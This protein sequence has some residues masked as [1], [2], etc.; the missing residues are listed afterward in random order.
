MAKIVLAALAVLIGGSASVAVTLAQ[1]TRT[2]Q[3]SGPLTIAH[4][5]SLPPGEPACGGFYTIGHMTNT[6]Y[7][8]DYAVGLGANA[9]EIDLQFRRGGDF[10]E[11]KHGW[12]CPCA[13]YHGGICEKADCNDASSV[14]EMLTHIANKQNAIGLV[15]IDSKAGDIRPNALGYAGNKLAGEIIRELYARGY[16]GNVILGVPKRRYMNLL[17]SAHQNLRDH[18]PRLLNRVR[19]SIDQEDNNAD[20]VINQLSSFTPQIAY[21]TGVSFASPKYRDGIRRAQARGIPFTYIWTVNDADDIQSYLDVGVTAV[22]T[23]HPFRVTDLAKKRGLRLASRGDTFVCR[24]RQSTTPTPQPVQASVELTF[25]NS[26]QDT[27]WPVTTGTT[28]DPFGAVA[29]W[30]RK[31]LSALCTTDGVSTRS[32]A[33]RIRPDGYITDAHP[34]SSLKARYWSDVARPRFDEPAARIVIFK[35]GSIRVTP[36][37]LLFFA[38]NLAAQLDE[39]ADVLRKYGTESGTD[40]LVDFTV[41][42]DGSYHWRAPTLSPEE[43]SRLENEVRS[44]VDLFWDRPYEN[45]LQCGVQLPLR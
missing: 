26:C 16:T 19:F 24:A 31:A 41:E 9:I 36:A 29:A 18:A 23:D 35:D 28:T 15:V 21:G 2:P 1:S 39:A 34:S 12:P 30:R 33:I 44:C 32:G 7:L 14:D 13:G 43:R 11:F 38:P 17:R 40:P 5:D 3:S 45:V 4:G 25:A 6:P 20:G 37:D 27:T 22:M 8:V 42:S 10:T